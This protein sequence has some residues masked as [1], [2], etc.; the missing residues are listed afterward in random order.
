MRCASGL[1]RDIDTAHGRARSRTGHGTQAAPRCCA[2]GDG[3]TNR[4]PQNTRSFRD[5]RLPREVDHAVGPGR[6]MLTN[7]SDVQRLIDGRAVEGPR[8]S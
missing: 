7:A 4:A 6:A 3:C 1:D 8:W 5:R 2:L